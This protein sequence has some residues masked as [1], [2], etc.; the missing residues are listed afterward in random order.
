MQAVWPGFGDDSNERLKI[1][2]EMSLIRADV[3]SQSNHVQ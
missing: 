1:G 2:N 3:Y